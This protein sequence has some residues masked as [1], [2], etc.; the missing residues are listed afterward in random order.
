MFRTEPNKSLKKYIGRL[1]TTKT[2]I[3]L[4]HP[5]IG[6]AL[7]GTTM[8]LGLA[9]TSPNNALIIHAIAAPIFFSAI[10]AIYFK[11]SNYTTPIQTAIA[12]TSFVILMDFFLVAPF[13]ERSFE[14]FFSIFGTW[15]PFLL[16]FIST[17]LT[18]LY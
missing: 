18:G 14:M 16:M 11:K 8:K 2:V 9:I 15:I 1:W 7:C 4:I 6:W 3:F 10:S 5:L 17:Y 13:F 12:F